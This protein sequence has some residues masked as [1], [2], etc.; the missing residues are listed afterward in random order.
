MMSQEAEQQI[1][2]W[3]RLAHN[4]YSDRK[5]VRTL[6]YFHRALAYA[7][8]KDMEGEIAAI[9]RD[10]GYVY[11]REGSLSEALVC[12]EQGLG[13]KEVDLSIRTGL[14]ANKASVLTRLGEYH[15]ALQL[16]DESSESIRTSFSNFSEAP[17]ELVHSYAAI[18]RM[19]N[20]LR[21]IVDLLDMGVRADR[22]QVDIKSPE[23]RWLR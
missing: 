12:F 16:L 8:E 9:C 15:H 17:S 13:I 5:I 7:Q 14:M 21:K 4:S 2:L 19:A 3:L 23:P 10:L 18:V 20:D 6:H 1:K 11:A 22:I